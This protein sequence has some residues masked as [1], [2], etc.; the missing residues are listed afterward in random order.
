MVL[1]LAGFAISHVMPGVLAEVK[2][3]F[4][5]DRSFYDIL[6]TR[7][8]ATKDEVKYISDIEP[9]FVSYRDSGHR[10]TDCL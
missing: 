3:L 9:I 2:S 5:D 1:F 7:K 8:D 4:G 6:N 10:L